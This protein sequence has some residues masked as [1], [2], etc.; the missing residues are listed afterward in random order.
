M[1]G[2][3]PLSATQWKRSI[4]VTPPRD[5]VGGRLGLTAF[6][7]DKVGGDVQQALSLPLALCGKD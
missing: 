4:E 6:V 3:W 7:Q 5:A 1:Y 2:P